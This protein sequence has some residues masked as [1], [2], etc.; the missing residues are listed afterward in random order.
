MSPNITILM[1]VKN[2]IEF[3]QIIE[4]IISKE[5]KFISDIIVMDDNSID[6]TFEA[7]IN[8]EKQLK[9]LKVYRNNK[10]LTLN[11]IIFFL[12]TK[13]KSNYVHIRAPHDI[14]YEGFYEHHHEIFHKF[15]SIE[16]SINKV[17][18]LSKIRKTHFDVTLNPK[19]S[20]FYGKLLDINISS[21]GFVCQTNYLKD[22]WGQ[23]LKFGIYCDWLIKKDIVYNQRHVLTFKLLSLYND[24]KIKDTDKI[25]PTNAKLLLNQII[26]KFW[27]ENYPFGN[28]TFPWNE[29]NRQILF[30]Q[31]LQNRKLLFICS[32]LKW[33]FINFCKLI[34]KKIYKIM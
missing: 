28:F 29:L 20:S 4:E 21:C 25:P 12:L 33:L 31:I 18:L 1:P 3:I 22:L 5:S 27:D 32:L 14:Y 11:E 24:L 10:K 19:V 17:Q 23:S 13:V 26:K 2:E 9:R 8:M 16:A 34:I 7:L 30:K 6:G 15:S